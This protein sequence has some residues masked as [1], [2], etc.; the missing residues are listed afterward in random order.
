M[1]PI[2]RLTQM[3]SASTTT[4]VR[5]LNNSNL[6]N[7]HWCHEAI[8]AG[9]IQVVWINGTDNLADALTKVTVGEWRQYL[10]TEFLWWSGLWAGERKT[11][12]SSC[13]YKS[14]EILRGPQISNGSHSWVRKASNLRGLLNIH[15]SARSLVTMTNWSCVWLSTATQIEMK[16]WCPSSH[17]TFSAIFRQ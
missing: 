7:Y 6:I 1:A 3:M 14:T 17:L 15:G 16:D 11:Q 12:E 13:P 10:F 4:P 5:K 9:H 2:T 8:A